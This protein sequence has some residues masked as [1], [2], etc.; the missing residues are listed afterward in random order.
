[1]AIAALLALASLGARAS[2][3]SVDRATQ[4][5]LALDAHPDRG[6]AQFGQYCARCHGSQA[7]GDAGRAIPVLAGQ[8]FAYLIRQLANFSGRERDSNTMHG[9]LSQM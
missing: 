4:T 1:M 9:V 7:Q 8:R 3:E 5:A 2:E 6:A